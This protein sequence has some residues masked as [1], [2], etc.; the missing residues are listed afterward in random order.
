MGVMRKLG[1]H[2]ARNPYPEPSWLQVVGV[3]EN[4]AIKDGTIL[5][6]PA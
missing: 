3:L 6:A 4:D 5:S 1:M 2:L